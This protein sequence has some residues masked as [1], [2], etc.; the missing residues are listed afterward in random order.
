MLRS[1]KFG[2]VQARN[3]VRASR[4]LN[5]EALQLSYTHSDDAPS[6]N[7]YV[8]LRLQNIAGAFNLGCHLAFSG[9]GGRC[10]QV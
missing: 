9:I 3:I 8:L 4:V 5:V 10:L 2:R 1:A 7:K 6:S